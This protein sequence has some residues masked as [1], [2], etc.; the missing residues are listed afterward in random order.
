MVT[1]PLIYETPAIKAQKILSAF[2]TM[3]KD[4]FIG[5]PCGI[6]SPLFSEID[7]NAKMIYAPR[8]DNAI[9]MACGASLSGKKPVV[10]MQN[11]GFAQSL[12]VLASLVEPFQIP[13]TLIISLRGCGIDNTL[14]N[15]MMG[16]MTIKLLKDLGIES[17][18]L[19]DENY[20]EEI[21]WSED[22][23]NSSGKMI[24]LLVTP[25]FFEWR[26]NE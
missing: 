24:A 21:N 5:T 16:Q 19:T 1:K 15:T 20:V 7:S 17:K 10:L 6:L 22:Y 26:P 9:A 4:L 13:F 25:E 12:N 2:T 3:G 23:I 11:S 14:E 18:T 8:E